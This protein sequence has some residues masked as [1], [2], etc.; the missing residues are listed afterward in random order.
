LEVLNTK[1]QLTIDSIHHKM[2]SRSWFAV[3]VDSLYSFLKLFTEYRTAKFSQCRNRCET[4]CHK[5][6]ILIWASAKYNKFPHIMMI[7]YI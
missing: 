3:T 7:Y 5:V 1:T 6:F 2:F 4:G